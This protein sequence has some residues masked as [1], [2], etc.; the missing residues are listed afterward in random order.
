MKLWDPTWHIW[1]SWKW[2]SHRREA[3]APEA[4]PVDLSQARKPRKE[5]MEGSSVELQSI[6]LRDV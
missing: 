2:Q 6:S 5:G 3:G 4:A 1:N